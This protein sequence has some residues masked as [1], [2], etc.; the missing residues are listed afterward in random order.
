MIKNLTKIVA[1]IRVR[2]TPKRKLARVVGTFTKTV[3]ELRAIEVANTGVI[4]KN[5]DRIAKIRQKNREL[6]SEGREAAAIARNI[7]ALIGR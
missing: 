2:L 6:D 5:S 4:A 1:A 7:E 3:R